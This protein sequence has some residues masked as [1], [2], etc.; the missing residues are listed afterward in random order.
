MQPA[1][2]SFRSSA[3]PTPEAV[4]PSA[5]SASES[6]ASPIAPLASPTIPIED[7][8]ETTIVP[9]SPIPPSPESTASTT[10]QRQPQSA[11]SLDTPATE[12]IAPAETPASESLASPIA[13]PTS[14]T[15][16]IEE[17]HS[18]ETIT[19][20][21]SSNA[22]FSESTESTTIQRQPQSA[23]A[24]DSPSTQAIAPLETPASKSLA[25]PIAPPTSP[26][27]PIE[28]S[29]SQETATDPASPNHSSFPEIT[30]SITIQRQ[31]QSPSASDSPATEAIAPAETRA[32]ESLATP[33]AH[34]TTPVDIDSPETIA[35]P[36]SSPAA[37]PASPAPPVSPAPP[38]FPAPPTSQRKPQP[39]SVAAA[40]QTSIPLELASDPVET[41]QPSSN[42]GDRP[43]SPGTVA[44]SPQTQSE[45][46]VVDLAM[47]RPFLSGDR[48]VQKSVALP[49]VV[50]Y[51]GVFTPLRSPLM[52]NPSAD[53]GN[54]DAGRLASGIESSPPN[55][56][57]TAEQRSADSLPLQTGTEATPEEAAQLSQLLDSF[58]DDAESDLGERIQRQVKGPLSRENR[59]A[60]ASSPWV[61]QKAAEPSRRMATRQSWD[62]IADLLAQSAPHQTIQTSSQGRSA[63]TGLPAAIPSSTETARSVA[64]A[65][66]LKD[67]FPNL[68]ALETPTPKIQQQPNA[69][70]ISSLSPTVIQRLV[71]ADDNVSS[72]QDGEVS[73]PG[74]DTTEGSA[75]KL[76]KLA[77]V[78]YQMVR[79][80]LAIE[81]E[82]LGRF[83][84]GRFQ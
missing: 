65:I 10:L 50:R 72:E 20:L 49:Q 14:P 60:T 21:T 28:D 24:S 61:R 35:T 37:T 23:S 70:Q 6:L 7:R 62:S 25:S 79:Q 1:P 34:P 5:A 45:P 83:G 41:S 46:S 75:A 44:S 51:V 8:L 53:E 4:Q 31:P 9:A 33:I 54:S 43:S 82:R 81:R 66:A 22:P 32:S 73:E 84:S 12:A 27:T 52:L 18:Q 30:E 80:R 40:D 67:P 78:M 17:G 55:A 42:D 58:D 71:A 39:P 2:Q 59:P 13:P 57:I 77:Q 19:D 48:T 3:I 56:P 68:H 64:A 69:L 36:F 63:S 29:Q 76:D 11:S 74:D 38:A 47:E 15:T 26:T 16:P